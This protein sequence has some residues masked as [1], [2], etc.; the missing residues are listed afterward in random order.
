MHTHICICASL[1]LFVHVCVFVHVYN[2]YTCNCTST[3]MNL[4][5]YFLASLMPDV[6]II[7]DL[8]YC[9]SCKRPRQASKKLDLWRLPEILVVH[10]KRFSYSRIIKNK[11]ETFVDFPIDDL[12]LLNFISHKDSQLSNRY[13]LYAISNHYGG[14]GGGHYTA[15]IDVSGVHSSL[16]DF[17]YCF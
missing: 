15:F 13:V 10:L 12:D 11:L 6:S 8:R 1:Y 4:V 17:S 5:I 14:M 3:D 9:P 2:M 7:Y 16:Y